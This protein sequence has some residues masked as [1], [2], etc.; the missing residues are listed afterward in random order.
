MLKEKKGIQI[1]LLL[2]EFTRKEPQMLGKYK[3]LIENNIIIPFKSRLEKDFGP[4]KV[5]IQFDINSNSYIL[6]LFLGNFFRC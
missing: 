3:K 2:K 6:I 4:D 5:V 1:S